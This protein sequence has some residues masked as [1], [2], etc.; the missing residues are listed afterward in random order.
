MIQQ[1][2]GLSHIH[3]I[4]KRDLKFIKLKIN[5][6]ILSQKGKKKSVTLNYLQAINNL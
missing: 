1:R 5:E 6:I 2:M 3:S 4:N